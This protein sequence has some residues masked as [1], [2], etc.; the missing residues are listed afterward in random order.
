MLHKKKMLELF[1]VH[2]STHFC[3][4]LFQTLDEEMKIPLHRREIN[5]DLPLIGIVHQV[6]SGSEGDSQGNRAR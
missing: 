2:L 5:F 1:C 3:W 4:Q 6:L